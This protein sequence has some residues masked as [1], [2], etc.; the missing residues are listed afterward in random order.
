M[1]V[2]SS[3]FA[4][5]TLGLVAVAPIGMAT[6]QELSAKPAVLFT[7]VLGST[8]FTGVMCA[9]PLQ[10]K[11]REALG[12][13]VAEFQGRVDSARAALAQYALRRYV[14][15]TDEYLIEVPEG[16]TENSV[17]RSLN[18]IGGFEYVEPDW[19]VFPVDCPDDPQFSQQWQHLP[20]RLQ[21]CDAWDLE[22][23]DPNIIVT[24]CDTGIRTTHEDLQLHRREG[25]HVPTA[26]MESAGGPVEDM[27]GHGT[28]CTG[29][30]AGNG[31]NGV[32]IAGAG[33]N[34]GHR[35]MR[36][37]DSATGGA[38]ISNLTDAARTAADF[39]DHV[40][41]VSYSGVTVSTV[42]SAGAYVRSQGAL[43]VWAAGNASDDL[44]GSRDDSVI[45]VGAT[46]LSEDLATFSNFGSFVDLTA[47]GVGVRTTTNNSDS[48]YTEVDGTSFACPLVA[49]L[50]GL[51]WSRNP[52]L[53]PDEVE[54]ILRASCEDLGAPGIDDQFGYGRINSFMALQMTPPNLV[55]V[56][57]PDGLPTVL[58]PMGG[59][60]LDVVVNPASSSADPAGATLWINAGA[61]FMA[62]SVPFIGANTFRAT[63]PPIACDTN[64]SYYF[65][66]DLVGGGE[67]I[68]PFE[69]DAN[70]FTAQALSLQT[71]SLDPV[72][73]GAGWVVGHPSD[74]AT[75][76]IWEL[77][78]P[79]GTAAA[80]EDDNTPGGTHCFVTGQS[81]VGGS[82]GSNDVD[83][84]A[85]SLFSPVLSLSMLPNPYLGYSRW[86][87]NSVQSTGD[88]IFTVDIT[89]DGGATWINVETLGPDPVAP[90]WVRH[91][92]RVLDFV[93][94]LSAVQ[95]RFR[96]EDSGSPSII[97]A[98]VDDLEVFEVCPSGCGVMTF[99][100]ST[101][102]STG[103]EAR[104]GF[105][106]S[107][108]VAANDLTLT[109]EGAP[110]SSFGIFLQ[111]PDEGFTP[112]AAGTLCLG[113][114]TLG[115]V[116]RLGALQ[117]DALGC[118]SSAFDNTMP[119]PPVPHVAP[120]E[121]WYFQFVYRD[122]NSG[123]TP[124]FNFSDGLAVTFCQ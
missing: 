52:T 112:A 79:I 86:Y 71:L 118:A 39:G 42:E 114:Q 44:T 23:G 115:F 47:P 66:F 18:A 58:D 119:A 46:T 59:D 111:S 80:P 36:V 14:P 33:W 13:S 113:A 105:T 25:Y 41:S 17:A 73:T 51:I 20:D 54:A 116:V 9:R 121:T 2:N 70:P 62:Q 35:M 16:E 75:T 78:D 34:L 37:S 83:G 67:A 61:G 6:T 90:G 32:G 69:G 63:F 1:Q 19:M 48:A 29:L 26:T 21:S 122:L 57:Y 98:G 8:E 74:T 27:V 124:V 72:E 95:L 81:P 101:V 96:A 92:F 3:T 84:G 103:G 99:C 56:A 22:T 12:I 91:S 76:G 104:I 108:S 64:V 89:A 65:E 24:V 5:F 109:A 102:N 49:G 40:V 123:G 106:G 53:T 117:T 55:Q 10:P 60:T 77:V 120:G 88:D 50:C 82:I 93:T 38:P 4:L 31:D 110:A 45:V 94:D 28:Q 11:A 30:A 97:E 68:S 43:L 100:T 87:A 85:T 7:E 107:V 15:E